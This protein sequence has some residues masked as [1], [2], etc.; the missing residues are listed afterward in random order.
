[1]APAEFCPVR[2]A[3]PGPLLP[4]SPHMLHSAQVLG[5][6]LLLE[7]QIP[8]TAGAY[9]APCLSFGERPHSIPQHASFMIRSAQVPGFGLT[10]FMLGMVGAPVSL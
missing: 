5:V 2:F 8:G 4:P 9:L 1:M 10:R 3:S 6:V 7:Q